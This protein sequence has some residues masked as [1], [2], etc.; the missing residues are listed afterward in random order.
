MGAL[1]LAP[2]TLAAQ[3]FSAQTSATRAAVPY[4]LCGIVVSWLGHVYRALR[5][6]F[7]A[8]DRLMLPQ[9]LR[10]AAITEHRHAFGSCAG[11]LMLAPG[12]ELRRSSNS[13]IAQ[14]N[15]SRVL[16]RLWSLDSV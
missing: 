4:W 10:R 13:R 9:A 14:R 8:S 1:P 16:H 2:A 12:A 11:W 3:R 15:A 7:N 5:Q 6:C